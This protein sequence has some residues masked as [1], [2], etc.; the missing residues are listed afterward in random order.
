MRRVLARPGPSPRA[1]ADG[2][3]STRIAR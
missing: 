1:C 3:R 2:S